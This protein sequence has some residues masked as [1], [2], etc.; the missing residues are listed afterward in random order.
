MKNTLIALLTLIALNSYSED[1]TT[2]LKPAELGVSGPFT[3]IDGKAF[4]GANLHFLAPMDDSIMMGGTS[5]VHFHSE[6]GFSTVLVPLDFT[7]RYTL[8][9]NKYSVVPFIGTSLGLTFSKTSFDT[10]GIDS[11]TST[12]FQ[13]LL[14]VGVHLNSFLFAQLSVGTT[15]ESFTLAPHIGI[16]F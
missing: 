8:G 7:A 4:F 13:G 10:P 6:T 14:H 11:V 1:S 12:K 2:S 16:K 15:L 3:L 9:A 5:G